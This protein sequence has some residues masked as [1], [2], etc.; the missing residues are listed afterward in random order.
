MENIVEIQTQEYK[1][2]RIE[3]ATGRTNPLD[4]VVPYFYGFPLYFYIS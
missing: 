3:I 1:G 4:G 2:Y